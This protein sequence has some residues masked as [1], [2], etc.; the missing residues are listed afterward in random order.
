MMRLIYKRIMSAVR[1]LKRRERRAPPL[2]RISFHLPDASGEIVDFFWFFETY[3]QDIDAA[4][5]ENV[6]DRLAASVFIV[7]KPAFAHEFHSDN[8]FA[9]GFDLLEHWGDFVSRAIH[10]HAVGIDAGM[11]RIDPR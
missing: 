2:R 11:N 7:A 9:G 3:V 5:A 6:L 10:H 8:R 1:T 4:E